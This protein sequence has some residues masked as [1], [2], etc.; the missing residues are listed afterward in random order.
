MDGWM[1][2]NQWMNEQW[3]GQINGSLKMGISYEEHVII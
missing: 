3:I 1:D 2:W